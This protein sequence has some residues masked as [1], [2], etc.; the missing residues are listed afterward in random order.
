LNQLTILGIIVF[1]VGI[2]CFVL[3]CIKLRVFTNKKRIKDTGLADDLYNLA[4]I[5]IVC[6]FF[7]ATGTIVTAIG[8]NQDKAFS[9]EELCGEYAI[10]YELVQTVAE[11]TDYTEQEVADFFIIVSESNVEAYDAIKMLDSSLTEKQINAIME[12][13][14]MRQV[15]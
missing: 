15:E 10:S 4:A 13:S 8:V 11:Y 1:I 5:A 6:G 12:I 7:M 14:A 9:V 2:V 3:T